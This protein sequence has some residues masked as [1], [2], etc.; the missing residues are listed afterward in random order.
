MERLTDSHLLLPSGVLRIH[1]PSESTSTTT[2]HKDEKA[3]KTLPQNTPDF[4][5]SHLLGGDSLYRRDFDDGIV[6]T[7]EPS[8]P[9]AYGGV[10]I[11]A[12]GSD[13]LQYRGTD[14]VKTKNIYDYGFAVQ[15]EYFKHIIAALKAQRVVRL[16]HDDAQQDPY[17]IAVEN[18]QLKISDYEHRMPRSIALPHAHVIKVGNW[19]D[20]KSPIPDHYSFRAEQRLLQ[21]E[22][23]FDELSQFYRDTLGSQRDVFPARSLSGIALRKVS[24][25]G[26]TI[27]TNIS[28][29]DSAAQQARS[30]ADLMQDH[31]KVYSA[32]SHK[33]INAANMART[34]RLAKEGRG[35][36]KKIEDQII[37]QPSYRTYIYYAEDMLRVTISPSV[38]STTGV[39]EAANVFFH[40]SPSHAP[41]YSDNEMNEF[42]ERFTQRFMREVA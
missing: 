10:M 26:Y 42:R 2:M 24:P 21:S 25:F 40:R 17:A 23:V 19:T 13:V 4:L 36:F 16:P 30:L 7:K 20:A 8:K 6:L 39:I 32:Y 1:A 35:E 28:F 38:L 14:I 29:A 9:Y 22:D 11:V 37:P 34:A 12:A 33:K 27:L 15:H 3:A 18:T 31:H 41:V 5:R